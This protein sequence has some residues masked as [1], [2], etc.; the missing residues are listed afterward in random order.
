M[1]DNAPR[2]PFVSPADAIDRLATLTPSTRAALIAATT[3]WQSLL[4]SRLVSL[5]LF[6]SVARG[7]ARPDS[8]I[9]VLVVAEGFAQSLSDRR[10]PLVEAWQRVRAEQSMAGVEWNLITK[11][12]EEACH[13][14]PLYLDIVEDGIVLFDQNGF[15]HAV[16]DRMRSRMRALGSRRVW[17]PDGTWYWDLKPDFQFGEIVEI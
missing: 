15:F 3:A 5:V 14:T 13:H 10:R 12:P 4:G 1:P 7:D 11:T 6:G 16:I 2:A 17:L 9:D 8:D